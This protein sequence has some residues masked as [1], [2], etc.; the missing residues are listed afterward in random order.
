MGFCYLT[1]ALVVDFTLKSMS[2]TQKFVYLFLL[3]KAL[4]A[5]VALSTAKEMRKHLM[6]RVTG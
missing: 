2:C 6:R 1:L 4:E 3:H 5:H